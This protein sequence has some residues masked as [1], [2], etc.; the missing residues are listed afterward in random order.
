[1]LL[2]VLGSLLVAGGETRHL[3]A[4]PHGTAATEVCTRT[5]AASRMSCTQKRL[6][7][8]ILLSSRL[9][10]E[11]NCYV[12]LCAAYSALS[13]ACSCRPVPGLPGVTLDTLAQ[14]TY[15]NL[16]SSSSS[17]HQQLQPVVNL[18]YKLLRGRH[19]AWELGRLS[20]ALQAGAADERAALADVSM[21]LMHDHAIDLKFCV[22][23]SHPP[24]IALTSQQ[25]Q[26][27]VCVQVD[28]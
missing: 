23:C 2:G 4:A 12:Q 8:N 20:A 18:V 6:L 22:T 27:C 3:P 1:V 11:L 26:V 17:T 13:A 15:N 5:H 28:M 21:A 10:A 16:S 19:V 7:R 9:T 24:N 14:G 25:C